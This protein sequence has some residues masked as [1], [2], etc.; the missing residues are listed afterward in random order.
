M[1]QQHPR[2]M[3]VLWMDPAGVP[4]SFQGSCASPCCDDMSR[5][6][7]NTCREHENPFA[8]S[9][10]LI[11]YSA[12]FDE[13]GLIIH[14]GSQSYVLIGHCPWCATKLPD[15]QRDR[16]FD[17]LAAMG[18]DDPFAQSIP[19]AYKSATWRKHQN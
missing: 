14:D 12:V 2:A 9:D 11:A 8:C 15:S 18:F 4:R 7:T 17:T 5:A 10:S 1:A 13:Y 16:W 3:R 6:L 19:E